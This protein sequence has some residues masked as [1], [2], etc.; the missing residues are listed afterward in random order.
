MPASSTVTNCVN[1]LFTHTL[2][3]LNPLMS[4]VCRSSF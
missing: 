4:K 1:S 2:F 3:T